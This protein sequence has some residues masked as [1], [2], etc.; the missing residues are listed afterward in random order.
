MQKIASSIY[1]IRQMDDLARQHSAIHSLHPLA[2]LIAT[3]G[4]LVAVLSFDRYAIGPLLPFFLYPVL[5]SSLAGISWP[6]LLRR[7]LWVEPLV[8]G[9]GL[10]NLLFDRL[11]VA[12]GPLVLSSGWLALVSLLLKSVL[13]L[14]ATFLLLMTTGIEKLAYALQILKVPRLFILQILLTYRY[15]L[16]L[17]EELSRMLRSYFLRAPSKKGLHHAVWGPFAGQLLL[18]TYDRAS[19]VYQAMVLRGFAGTFQPGPLKGF[20]WQD[21][22]FTAIVWSAAILCRLVDL[23]LLLGQLLR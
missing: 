11:P 5:V 4:Y 14:S 2:K 13:T 3:L 9:I 12:L 21:A 18:R 23:P 15:I 20:T 10:G 1:Q 7:I 8:L 17:S 16:V 19:R 6:I 22:V